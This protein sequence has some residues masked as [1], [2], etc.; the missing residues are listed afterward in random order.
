MNWAT[1]LVRARTSWPESVVSKIRSMVSLAVLWLTY[2]LSLLPRP[3]SFMVLLTT[4]CSE[5]GLK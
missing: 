5:V 3:V 1:L 2:C 4:C